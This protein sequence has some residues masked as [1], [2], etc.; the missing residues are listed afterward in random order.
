MLDMDPLPDP[1]RWLAVSI[2]MPLPETE[3]LERVLRD[4]FRLRV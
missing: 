4:T 1:V 3:E 2:D